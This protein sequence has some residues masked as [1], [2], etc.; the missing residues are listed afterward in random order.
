MASSPGYHSISKL[1]A[2]FNFF[3]IMTTFMRKTASKGSTALAVAGPRNHFCYS[4]L[5]VAI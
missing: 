2:I 3:W 4:L 1:H 5:T